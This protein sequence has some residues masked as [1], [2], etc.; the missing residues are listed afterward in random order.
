MKLFNIVIITIVIIILFCLLLYFLNKKYKLFGGIIGDYTINVTDHHQSKLKTKDIIDAASNYLIDNNNETIID[1]FK[2]NHKKDIDIQ[3]IEWLKDNS[4]N[5]INKITQNDINKNSVYLSICE[6]LLKIYMLNYSITSITVL[7]E[8]KYKII[9]NLTLQKV[10]DR[11]LID[12]EFYNDAYKYDKKY[13][14]DL[15][16]TISLVVYNIE[17]L[18][19]GYFVNESNNMTNYDDKLMLICDEQINNDSVTINN[20]KIV[21]YNCISYKKQFKNNNYE[22]FEYIKHKYNYFFDSC[23]CNID[24]IITDVTANSFYV[25]VGKRIGDL[26]I[27]NNK[28]TGIY[29]NEECIYTYTLKGYIFGNKV[30]NNTG[31]INNINKNNDIIIRNLVYDKKLIKIDGTYTSNNKYI[32]EKYIKRINNYTLIYE[33]NYIY[34]DNM[35]YKYDDNYNLYQCKVGEDLCFQIYFNKKF[36]I[37]NNNKKI[38]QLFNYKGVK[39]KIFEIENNKLTLNNNEVYYLNNNDQKVLG[40]YYIEKYNNMLKIYIICKNTITK[41][42]NIIIYNDGYDLFLYAPNDTIKKDNNGF[43]EIVNTKNHGNNLINKNGLM[44]VKENIN[45]TYDIVLYNI[46]RN[47]LKYMRFKMTF[48]GSINN[49]IYRMNIY[50]INN[51]L[52]TSIDCIIDTL[53]DI[54]CFKYNYID[55]L[56]IYL[57]SNTDV[58]YYDDNQDYYIKPDNINN[59]LILNVFEEDVGNES[60]IFKII[61]NKILIDDSDKNEELIFENFKINNISL[62]IDED[63]DIYSDDFK[64]GHLDDDHFNFD[65]LYSINGNTTIKLFNDDTIIQ[66]LSYDNNTNNK[67]NYD[68]NGS[69]IT[70]HDVV[71]YNN[72]NYYDKYEV[73]Y[74]LF[75]FELNTNHTY[76]NICNKIDYMN[77]NMWCITD[78]LNKISDNDANRVKFIS[79]YIELLKDN[80]NI[81]KDDMFILNNDY[82]LL[83]YSFDLENIKDIKFDENINDLI[84]NS[85]LKNI[86]KY[87]HYKNDKNKLY[88]SYKLF[89]MLFNLFYGNNPGESITITEDIIN[90]FD[91]FFVCNFGD[92]DKY[93]NGKFIGGYKNKNDYE[94]INYK[95]KLSLYLLYFNNKDI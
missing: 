32:D 57:D 59:T 60:Y 56:N 55:N 71:K 53:I 43:Y 4:K 31:N 19:K 82:I 33:P 51:N 68:T 92:I 95:F 28:I 44:Y 78:Q 30:Y 26:I 3:I 1:T 80:I 25:C 52:I 8:D 40:E 66:K 91:N 7:H 63:R 13:Q 34:F 37:V 58:K 62:C 41:F 45:T 17:D 69:S 47:N 21:Y 72:N 83:N 16:T 48:N 38:T 70:I 39:N 42:S 2:N 88:E 27:Y 65:F 67:L 24:E 5:L 22:I 90:V 9:F 54:E 29:D 14:T 35:I 93:N 49:N 10:N 20:Y 74:N 76:V 12:S 85:I 86:N 81:T 73:F 46:F 89:N 64:I 75:K 15:P 77:K 36:K 61:N 94:D 87:E 18:M 23:N 11:K 84:I 50:D 79:K 6:A